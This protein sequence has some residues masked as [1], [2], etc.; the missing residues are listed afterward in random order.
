MSSS[1]YS[2]SDSSEDLP[3]IST[4]AV[5]D[6][7]VGQEGLVEV[8]DQEHFHFDWRGLVHPCLFLMKFPSTAEEKEEGGELE[9]ASMLLVCGFTKPAEGGGWKILYSLD[10]SPV[11]NF[12]TEWSRK[13]DAWS[14]FLNL[15]PGYYPFD[16]FDQLRVSD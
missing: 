10:G 6:T 7:G 12:D 1:S 2:I 8:V 4:L 14:D 3:D 13:D 11:L 15:Y 16:S 9:P 5:D